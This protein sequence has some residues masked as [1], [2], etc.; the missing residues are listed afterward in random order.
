[1]PMHYYDPDN[2]QEYKKL[3]KNFKKEM[4]KPKPTFENNF[5]CYQE[6]KKEVRQQSPNPQYIKTN[7]KPIDQNNN[8]QVITYQIKTS[9]KHAKLTKLGKRR[10][11]IRNI[12]I[13]ILIL[14]IILALPIIAGYEVK[15]WPF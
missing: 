9:N 7:E 15:Y 5:E 12:S 6:E 14:T 3:K 4:S 8:E 1:M 13:Y 11:L 2:V 10:R